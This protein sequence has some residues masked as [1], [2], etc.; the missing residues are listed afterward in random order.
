MRLTG[1]RCLSFGATGK[2]PG[3]SVCDCPTR[4]PFLDPVRSEGVA[5]AGRGRIAAAVV[6]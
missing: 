3:V 4:R 6:L 5:G 1:D 2:D